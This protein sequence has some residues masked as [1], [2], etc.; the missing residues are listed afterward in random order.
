DKET[1]TDSRG[2]SESGPAPVPPAADSGTQYGVQGSPTVSGQHNGGIR[3]GGGSSEPSF[4]SFQ[5]SLNDGNPLL[6]LYHSSP[7]L[8]PVTW[9]AFIGALIWRGKI[10]TA[11]C[12][13]GYDYETFRLVA[14]MKGS[15]IRV[16]LLEAVSS[17]KN[18][19]QLANEFLVDWK[20]IDNHMKALSKNNLVAEIGVIGTARLYALTEHGKRVLALLAEAKGESSAVGAPPSSVTAT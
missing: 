13:Q 17:A 19:Q 11:W 12:S 10:R 15:P 9:A 5:P 14:R 7:Y 1:V 6:S 8:M 2:A 18:R 16:K 20:T 4:S 3:S